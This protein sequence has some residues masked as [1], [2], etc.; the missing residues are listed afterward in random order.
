MAALNGYLY[1]QPGSLHQMGDPK[2]QIHGDVFEPE[3]QDGY[4]TFMSMYPEPSWYVDV[5]KVKL[6]RETETRKSLHIHRQLSGQDKVGPAD[7]SIGRYQDDFYHRIHLTPSVLRLGNLISTQTREIEVW[8]AFFYG[9]EL[10]DVQTINGDGITVTPPVGTPY[11]MVALESL[12]YEVSISTD[13]P[14]A[15]KAEIR[16]VVDNVVIGSG[17]YDASISGNRVIPMPFAPDWEKPVEESLEWMTDVIKSYSGV[18]QRAKIRSKPRRGQTYYYSLHG[19]EAG[20]LENLLWG[21]QSRLF[22][23]PLWTE[24]TLYHDDL[25]AGQIGIPVDTDNYAWT[26]DSLFFVTNGVIYEMQEIVSVEQGQII[27]KKGLDNNWPRTTVIGPTGLARIDGDFSVKAKWETSN[28]LTSSIQFLHDPITTD[29][30]IPSGNAP[31]TYAFDGEEIYLQEPNWKDGLTTEFQSEGKVLDFQHGG[32]AISTRNGIP[33]I[34]EEYEWLLNGREDLIKFSEFLGRREGR[35]NGFW[36]PNWKHQFLIQG[37]TLSG[38]TGFVAT[39]NYYGLLV[40]GATGRNHVMIQLKDNTRILL[41]I[42]NAS[43]DTLT[44]TVNIICTET[45]GYTFEPE[46]VRIACMVN[47]YRLY[48][49]KIK[50]NYLDRNVATVKTTLV[51]VQPT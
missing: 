22:A 19:N 20:Q 4:D 21:W 37:T 11:D 47:W 6:S 9:V 12:I 43:T 35:L 45:M 41:E 50:M 8:N 26:P 51:A 24:T 48:N 34:V 16:Y 17:N 10:T 46:D 42:D 5:G 13:G 39:A 29:P 1:G 23:V 38:S 2:S 30:F 40:A 44:N 14:P 32:F 36:M 25:I 31:D 3:L 15:I 27:L 7:E 28:F 49:D 33:D 18:E